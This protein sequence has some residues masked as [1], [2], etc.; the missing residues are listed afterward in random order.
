MKQKTTPL[1]TAFLF[2]VCLSVV[3]VEMKLNY[4]KEY[5]ER[6]CGRILRLCMIQEG[7]AMVYLNE[8][9]CKANAKTGEVLFQ[10]HLHDYLSKA[11]NG[12]FS[13]K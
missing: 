2:S 6:N 13:K 8:Q 9:I 12:N 5:R 11:T 7:K 1:F 4:S 3:I 10:G